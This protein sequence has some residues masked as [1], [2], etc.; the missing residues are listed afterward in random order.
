[1]NVTMAEH[2]DISDENPQTRPAVST[3]ATAHGGVGLAVTLGSTHSALPG[4]A[5]GLP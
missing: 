5:A 1:M 4:P 3:S 2:G